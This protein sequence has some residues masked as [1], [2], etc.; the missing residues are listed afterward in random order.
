MTQ[1]ALRQRML[2]REQ[3]ANRKKH[4][5]RLV[6]A[7]NSAC[8]FCLDT[9]TPRNLFLP[10][11]TIESE[12]R[13]GRAELD[14]DKVILSGGEGS[15]HP[16]WLDII[17]Y[18]KSVGYERVQTVTNGYFLGERDF[19]ERS[20]QAGLGEITWSLHG[21]TEQL[22]DWLT[23]TPGAF[24]RITRGIA[25][26]ERDPRVI[27]NVDVCICKPN[28]AVLDKIVELAIRL[29]VTEFDLLHVIPQAA[30]FENRD[31]LFYDPAEHLETLHKVF[32]LNRHPGFVIW[33]NRFPVPFL[34]GLEDLI[35]DPH[36]MLDEV[37]G[38]RFMV[39]RYLDNGTPL[40]CRQ[41]ERCVHCFIE[42]FCTTMDRVVQGQNQ[43]S[44]DAWW[45]GEAPAAGPVFGADGDTLPFGCTLLGVESSADALPTD[46]GPLYARIHDAA[47]LP[48]LPA[49]SVAVARTAEQLSAWL[50]CLPDDLTVEVHLNRS[51]APWL[52]AH[53]DL[54]PPLLP[55]LTVHQPGWEHMAD[56]VDHDVRD[57]AS[58]FAELGLRVRTSG[59]PA[60]AAPGTELTE[61]VRVLDA[62]LFDRSTGRLMIRELARHHIKHGYRCHSLRCRQC[63][64]QDRCEGLP[65]NLVRDQ[66]LALARP[67]HGPWADDA[68]AQLTALHPAPLARPSR[69]EGLQPAAPS[70]PGYAAPSG[71]VLDPLAV[72]ARDKQ[73]AREQRRAALAVLQ[74]R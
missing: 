43:R 4:W 36:K 54:L 48:S 58:F 23:G 42:P 25:R 9:D 32:K 47:P 40:D 1:T 19:Y 59:L 67:L 3:V 26:A 69:G 50:P 12:L 33:T 72:V 57:P 52:L 7:C 22:H 14:A 38:R 27:S 61:G 34:E 64:V 17:R 39:R 68:A 56:A 35:Q 37:N 21:H 10:M 53:R 74:D 15:L 60:C 51:T 18:A 30:A 29:G 6:T 31:D 65:V 55:R 8:L 44:F 73:L 24:K 5:V 28:V 63:P 20:V 62:S 41:A 13:R 71:D 66:G 70:L 2:E 49:G 45:L 46:R 11:E 16:Q